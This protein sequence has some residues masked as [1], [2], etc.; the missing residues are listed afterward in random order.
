MK[1][2]KHFYFKLM[3]NLAGALR[4]TYLWSTLLSFILLA[5]FL[6]NSN[7]FIVRISLLCSV[8]LAISSL[9]SYVYYQRTKSEVWKTIVLAV[10]LFSLP[11]LS[12]FFTLSFQI[13]EGLAG[14]FFLYLFIV[15]SFGWLIIGFLLKAQSREKIKLSLN[16]TVFL[17]LLLLILFSQTYLF[18]LF[19]I[20]KN[21]FASVPN[22]LE[23]CL[24]IY[25]IFKV[26]FAS[27]RFHHSGQV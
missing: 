13:N 7:L 27:A 6:T 5:L 16:T 10:L 17:F 2:L 25:L 9:L 1:F 24:K 3:K 11:L 21:Y 4:K 15:I 23:I 14:Y 18:F 12:Y 19:N 26:F 20:E 22:F 8:I